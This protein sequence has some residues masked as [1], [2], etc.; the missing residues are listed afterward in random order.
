MHGLHQLSIIPEKSIAR[1]DQ[2]PTGT[3]RSDARDVKVAQ[4]LFHANVPE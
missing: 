1:A 3:V 2:Q 4:T